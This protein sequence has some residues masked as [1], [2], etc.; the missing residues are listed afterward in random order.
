ME[1]TLNESGVVAT[2]SIGAIVKGTVQDT[3][4]LT[5]GS[6]ANYLRV[7]KS[8][9]NETAG[10]RIIKA[11]KDRRD[12][13]TYARALSLADIVEFIQSN[14]NNDTLEA[15]CSLIYEGYRKMLIKAFNAQHERVDLTL[16]ELVK[17]LTAEG[18]RARSANTITGED[19]V[20]VSKFALALASSVGLSDAVSKAFISQVKVFCS[21]T[22]LIPSPK[23]L[24]SMVKIGENM[25]LDADANNQRVGSGLMIIIENRASLSSVESDLF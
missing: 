24:N 25:L 8:L 7:E 5:N 4:V 23:L 16:A 19:F 12:F 2:V 15:F 10:I 1:N 14:D 17:Y 18:V 22:Q 11:Q 6:K 3:V 21:N 20:L 9:L 13:I